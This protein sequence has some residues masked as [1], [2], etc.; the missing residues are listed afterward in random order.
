[1]HRA[2]ILSAIALTASAA[3]AA[4]VLPAGTEKAS[5]AITAAGIRGAV[6]FLASDL[7]EGRAPS[8]RGDLLSRAYLAS[9]LEALGLRPGGFGGSWEQRFPTV[10]ITTQ[11]PELWRFSRGDTAVDLTFWQDFIAASGVQ[12]DTAAIRDA[13]LVF[14][15]YGIEADEYDWDDFKDVDVAGKV[16]VMLNNDPDWDPDLF[17][18]ERRLYYGRWDYKYEQAARHGAVGAIIVHTTPSAGYG[19]RVVQNSWTGE[20][21]ELPSTVAS[22][23]QVKAWTTE[24]ATRRLF[25]AA[26]QDL[27]RLVAEAHE[28]SFRPVPLALRTSLSLINQVKRAMSANVLGLLEGSDPELKR[29]VVV[30]TAHF[31]HLGIGTP[32]ETG[33]RIYNGA[34]DNA[35]G[36]AQVLAIAKAFSALP[37][38][39]RR[40]VLFLFVSGEESGLLGSSYFAQNPTVSPANLAACINFDAANIFGRTRDV[41]LIGEGKSSMDEV[42]RA[43]AALQGRKV[44]GETEPD[45]GS[46][47]RSDQFSLARIGVPA[48]YFTAGHEVI[49]KPPGW[50]QQQA[51]AWLARHYHRPSDQLTDDWD[52]FGLVE[53]ARLGFI[54]GVMVATADEMPHWRP[55]DEFAEVRS[56]AL[57]AAAAATR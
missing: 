42:A 20:Q 3:T 7:L 39:P 13:E 44:I 49:G 2:L 34:R 22:S 1:M 41:A 17:A 18:G 14:V 43:A 15:G 29:Q 10:G 8:H 12:A 37:T 9:Q 54:A 36:V 57:A 25:A 48:L 16:L 28:R 35:S 26:G 38:P 53:D 45:K 40:S 6:R 52:F 32:D 21:F 5:Q 33:D 11:V 47:Y 31:D 50:G 19:W 4:P 51:D 46:F 24:E 23:L 55:S 56:K 30:Y 27:D